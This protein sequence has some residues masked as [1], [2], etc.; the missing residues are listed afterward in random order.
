MD[1]FQRCVQDLGTID[2][3]LGLPQG[4]DIAVEV[5]R[6]V[7]PY[8]GELDWLRDRDPTGAVNCLLEYSEGLRGRLNA[9]FATR[10]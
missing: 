1:S 3:L 9:D 7:L 10:A 5:Y 6:E 2:R 8:L 4:H